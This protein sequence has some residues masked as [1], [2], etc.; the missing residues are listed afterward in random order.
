MLVC[1][2][3]CNIYHEVLCQAFSCDWTGICGLFLCLVG[4]L[5]SVLINNRLLTEGM[6]RDR[7]CLYIACYGR[8]DCGCIGTFNGQAPEGQ[9][10]EKYANYQDALSGLF[11]NAIIAM[12]YQKDVFCYF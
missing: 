12:L 5:P 1:G 2:D 8:A 4:R 3:V 10:W 7:L 6:Q 11:S 9:P